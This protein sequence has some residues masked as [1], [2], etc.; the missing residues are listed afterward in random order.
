MAK[1]IME[2]KLKV[3]KLLDKF[4]IDSAAYGIPTL[5]RASKEAREAIKI[6]YGQDLLASHQPRRITP[7]LMQWADIILVMTTGTKAGLPQN[8]TFTLKEFA[9]GSGDISDPYGQ[10]VAV[11]LQVADEI[12]AAMDRIITKIPI[13]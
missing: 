11:Y 2:Q 12:A 5:N 1:V 4:E 3:V 6:K 9:G 13:V 10:G 7:E 8:K